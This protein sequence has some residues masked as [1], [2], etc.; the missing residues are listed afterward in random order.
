MNEM[1]SLKNKNA[2]ITGATGILGKHFSRALADAGA[3]LALIDLD[4]KALD[5]LAGELRSQGIKVKGFACDI[6]DA[7]SVAKTITAIDSEFGGIHILHNNAASKGK[8]LDDFLAPFEEFKL[9]TWKDIMSV[10][11][12]GM[13]LMAQAV[14]KSMLKNGIKGSIIQTSSIYGVVGPDQRIYDGSFYM[15]RKI[16][17]PAVYSASKAAVIG[18]TKYLAAYWGEKGI[19]VNTLTPGGVESGQNETF[20]SKYSARIPLGRMGDAS[21]MCGALVFLASDASSYITGQNLIIDGGLTA[22]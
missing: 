20:K 2:V 8:N 15:N 19:R 22:W 3:N 5:T 10:N 6:T 7:A 21:E 1:F 14:G 16:S 17:S 11:I 13:F 18:L 4:Q 9:E 12:D